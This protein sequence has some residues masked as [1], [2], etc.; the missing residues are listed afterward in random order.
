MDRRNFIASSGAA[1]LAASLP[2]H[3]LAQAGSGD[4]ALNALFERIFQRV[5]AR[6]PELASQPA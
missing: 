2:T 4:S 6:S 5:V 1:A 3:V